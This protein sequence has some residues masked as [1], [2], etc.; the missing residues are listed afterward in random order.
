MR[1][2]SRRGS[3]LVTSLTV[4]F[5]VF[6]TGSSVLALS[7]QSS[8]RGLLDT[9]RVRA[10]ALADAGAEQAINYMRTGAPDGTND[11]TWRTAG[12]TETVAGQGDYTIVVEDGTGDNGGKLV[13][14]S[15]GRVTEGALTVKR[16]VRVAILLDIEDVSVW[17]N[18]IFGGVGQGSKSIN[19]NVRIRGNMHLLGD[20]ES[21]TDLDSDGRW[22]NNEAYTD[23]NANG[24]YDAGEPFTDTDSDGHRDA[25]EPFDDVNGNLARDPALTVTEL[26]SEFGGDANVGNN[27]EGMPAS[28][29]ALIPDPYSVNFRGETVQSLNSKLRVKHGRVD[30]Q[31][32]ATV[33]D[34]HADGGSPAIKETMSGTYVSDGFGG[35]GGTANVFSDN[36][37]KTKYD[38][39]DVVR[40]PTLTEPVVKGGVSY[41]TYMNYLQTA[42]MNLTGN[43][44]LKPG[45]PF[46]PVADGR[47]NSLRVDAMG[48]ITITGIVVVTGDIRLERNGGNKVMRYSG[49]GTMVSTGNTYISTDLTPT[50]PTFPVNH[51]MGMISRHRIELATQG[52]DSQLTLTGAFYA[53]EQVVSQKQNELAGSFV[54]S[55]FSMQNV[56]HMYQVP[57]LPAN[58]PP[59]MPGS[60]SIWVH[61]IRV[62]SWREVAPV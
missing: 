60:E 40:F 53:Q 29:R 3:A 35:S 21:F 42:G 25:K 14:T 7:V 6:V 4:L 13:I 39:E 58:L 16:A 37:T 5:V 36:G 57:K 2:R 46:G 56:P 32:T 30:L 61:M 43:L 41:P 55:Y 52:G 18:A 62:D 44:T 47:G 19:G 31:G 59:G 11:G 45:V 27:Y 50:S 33:G 23:S 9:M 49:R 34:E 1:F 17:N 48:N 20:G 22:D 12:L 26:S 15:T 51:A 54:S 8:R 28:L 10:L 38:L 24:A